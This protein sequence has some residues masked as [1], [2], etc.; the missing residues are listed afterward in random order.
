MLKAPQVSSRLQKIGPEEFKLGVC[1]PMV[2]NKDGKQ[3][4]L[5]FDV[6]LSNG[7]EVH[8]SIPSWRIWNNGVLS[9][10]VRQMGAKYIPAVDSTAELQDYII[11]L[12][13]EAFGEFYPAS[14]GDVKK[15]VKE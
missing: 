2:I 13:K 3:A 8:L 11:T 7:S 14:F 1:N 10:P 15:A 4:A 12:A 5:R 6:T 9:P